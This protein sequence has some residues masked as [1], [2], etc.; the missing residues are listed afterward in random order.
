MSIRVIIGR[1]LP[2]LA[3]QKLT[4]SHCANPPTKLFLSIKRRA[5]QAL[6]ASLGAGSVD[7]LASPWIDA[8][9]ARARHH[10]QFLVD[11]GAM[12]IP[13][14]TWPLAWTSV[15]QGL[16]R[17][18]SS[19]LTKAQAWSFNYLQ[20]ELQLVMDGAYTQSRSRLSGGPQVLEG[21]EST[22]REAKEFQTGITYTGNT[23]AMKIT[24]TFV[25]DPSDGKRG[26]IDG[27]YLA[28]LLGN[29]ATGVGAIDQWW[30]P[31]WHSSMILSTNARPAPGFFVKRNRT[32]AFETPL[33]SWLGEW[34]FTTFVNQLQDK[35]GLIEKPLLWG[36]RLSATPLQGLEIALSRTAMW[37]GDDDT[38]STQALQDVLLGNNE[39]FRSNSSHLKQSNQI[40]GFDVRYGFAVGSTLMAF[41]GQVTGESGDNGLPS[42]NIAMGGL[43]FSRMLFNSHHRIAFEGSNSI[44]SFY[45]DN[46]LYNSAYEHGTYETGYRHLGRPIG[47][48]SDG[49]SEVISL[50]GQHYFENGHQLTW[51]LAHADL[52]RDGTERSAPGGGAFGPTRTKVDN[53]QIQYRLPLNNRLMLEVGG[54]HLSNSV[55][56][57]GKDVKTTL[58]ISLFHHW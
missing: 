23:F 56:L 15:K 39:T 47:A 5:L 53:T 19:G 28:L 22:S 21:F 26:R 54:S 48:S 38:E 36:A 31:G 6:L 30:G 2:S 10:I 8:G 17:I 57:N 13:T 35:T 50:A 42:S 34:Q 55:I 32:D 14:S 25:D 43:E 16:D 4:L 51:R 58:H 9:N 44:V 11:S 52:N 7:A 29:W 40:G 41:Y 20:H 18:R 3:L 24:G 12:N 37:A 49:D 46:A 27:S 1:L 33:L 45:Q